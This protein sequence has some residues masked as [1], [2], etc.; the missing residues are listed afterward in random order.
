[1][2]S[3]LKNKPVPHVMGGVP[4]APLD[5]G[6][7]LGIKE[8]FVQWIPAIQNSMLFTIFSFCFWSLP[9]CRVLVNLGRD[10]CQW[11]GILCN[12]RT[13]H[14]AKKISTQTTQIS[15]TYPSPVWSYIL[16]QYDEL[17]YERSL[18]L[19]HLNY[20]NLSRNSFQLPKFNGLL[21]NLRCLNLSSALSSEGAEIPEFIG[22]LSSFYEWIPPFKLY[23]V[24]ITNCSVGPNFPAWLQLQT[25]LSDVTLR[26]TGISGT[27]PEEWLL[28][29]SLQLKYLDLSYNHIRGRLPLQLK[30][31]NLYHIDLSYNRF[32]GPLPPLSANLT[33]FNLE[34]YSFSGPIPS[35]IDQ[36][37]PTLQG[38][39]LSDNMLECIKSVRR[40]RGVRGEARPRQWSVRPLIYVVD[41]GYNNLSGNMPS[42]MGVPSSLHVL[43]MNDNNLGLCNL[44]MLDILDL[45]HNN[46]SGPIPK[47]CLGDALPTA[48]CIDQERRA[49][50]AFKEDLTDPSGRLSF[51]VG[52][53]CCQWK[54]ISCNNNTGHVE[55]MSL[56]NPYIY[57]LSVFD[58]AQDEMEYSSLGGKINPSL[59]SLKHLNYLDLSRN[60]FRGIH[61]PEFFGQLKNLR[62][63]NLSSAS[64]GGEIPPHLG[65]LSH[66][67]YLDLSEESDYSLLELPSENL[68]WLARLSSLKY[69]NLE[70]L[71]LSNTS[72][73][74]NVN[75]LPSLL[76]LHLPSCQIESLPLSLKTISFKSLLVLDMSYNDLKFPFPD[77][78]F[79]LGSLTKLDLSGN[80]LIGPFP[81]E[82][83]SLKSL[84]HLH[85]SFN[86]LEG[87]IPM[88]GNF[89][90]LKTLNLA[91]N[92]FDGGIQELFDG[93]SSCP[94]S[95][96]ESLDLSSNMLQ[97]NLPASVGML[98]NLKYLSLYNNLMNGSIPESLGQLSELVHLDLSFNPWVSILT[99]SH[100]INLT[101]LKYFALGRVD[102][103]PTLPIHLSFN[104]SYNWVPPFMLHTINIANCK[105]GPAFGVWLQSQTELVFVKLRGTGISD[106]IPKHWFLK[107]S[108]NV[109]YLDLS[110]NQI[111]GNLP[112]E[113]NFRNTLILDVSNNRIDGP[114][115][116]WSGNH[117]IRL[118]LEMNSIFG[119][120]P[121]NL[122][123][124]FP[125]LVAL[126]LA[127]NRLNGTI[128]S[129]ICN[130]QNL[131]VLSLR[132]NE[133]SGEF[134]QTWSQLHEILVI[135]AAHNNLSGKLPSSIG[136]PGALFGLKLNNNNFDGEIPLSLQNCTSLRHIDLGDN[137]FTGKIPSWI[138]SKVPLVSI[139][140]LRSNF[141]SGEVPQ[142]LCNL[143]Y[144]HILDLAHNNFSGIIPKCLNK[145]SAL[146]HGNFSAYDLYAFYD[147]ETSVVKVRQLDYQ[148]QTIMFV[149]SID[150]S[151]NNLEGE[152]PEEISSLAL[153]HNLNLSMNQ[154]RGSI[155]SKIGNLL[156]LE[157]L[158]LSIN[159]LSG[160][161]PQ[162]IS[163]PTFLS[164]LN[165][166]YNNLTGRIPLGSQLQTL[167][168]PSIYEGNPSLCGVPLSTKCPGD[169]HTPTKDND[170]EDGNDKFW[171]YVS[172]ALGFI[173]GF[174]GVCGTLVV[175]KTWRYAYFGW[176]DAIKDKVLLAIAVQMARFQR[177]V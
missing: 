172:I 65:N 151:S 135:D 33:I 75:M 145:L 121:L 71:D 72:W 88:L 150:L 154:L 4:L 126:Y 168:D 102:P 105:V 77:W 36:L 110:Y 131:L 115:P 118:E 70:G 174:W 148:P 160:E 3:K 95:K 134:P 91:S 157:A 116:L 169:D 142:Q 29:V 23:T 1:M 67:N 69:L 149:R 25:E 107:L 89:C 60:D 176:F 162:S 133:L 83:E 31:P 34:S 117:V 163:L 11:K 14:V 123:E 171:F 101:R 51:W 22:N 114:F 84:E 2:I 130:M 76:E 120:I 140:R 37:M 92:K 97:S 6:R 64:F 127:E 136:V 143:G 28:K 94:N 41:V 39:S 44:P 47:F 80:S 153:L 155:P 8:I 78:F 104:V 138:G 43:K 5:D 19:K 124:R 93:L 15:N 170:H 81:I 79:S 26:S 62:Y 164:H 38:L 106:S 12:N 147:Q 10:C 165:L 139:L 16:Y 98:R 74:H 53:N 9:I 59:L 144:L 141:F 17:A 129:S 21:E 108:S 175:K 158:D 30:C 161:I 96:L 73:L 86:G 137:K 57:T 112:L 18:F 173:V 13:G 35:N 40:G 109:E 63:L 85:L 24:G 113:L 61:I 146:T 27:I 177:N 54:G 119:H 82:L 166:S 111:T 68:N 52:R 49:L 48:K 128:P 55:K 100:F 152:I 159:H 167:T 58:A 50:L 56:Q 87:R 45:S 103:Y 66:L 132:N 99:E 32:D 156:L 125:K 122:D 46:F 90:S 7:S 42:S 20:L